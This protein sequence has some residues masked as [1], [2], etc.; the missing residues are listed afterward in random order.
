MSLPCGTCGADTVESWGVERMTY[1][2]VPAEL[3]TCTR[4]E[5]RRTVPREDLFRWPVPPPLPEPV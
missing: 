2:D 5:W 3:H 1:G 4:C